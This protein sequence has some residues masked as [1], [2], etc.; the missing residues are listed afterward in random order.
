MIRLI[1]GVAKLFVWIIS[2]V[3]LKGFFSPLNFSCSHSAYWREFFS[4]CSATSI[5]SGMVSVVFLSL[6][7]NYPLNK[8][9]AYL[10]LYLLLLG[11][12]ANIRADFE[13]QTL[14][15]HLAVYFWEFLGVIIGLI[16]AK[17]W[18]K[19]RDY[20]V[21]F[22]PFLLMGIYLREEISQ[23]ITKYFLLLAVLVFVAFLINRIRGKFLITAVG[24]NRNLEKN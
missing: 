12:L 8:I 3:I 7:I 24:W 16:F 1:D 22:P 2:L 23:Q 18:F 15:K 10:I 5:A 19:W 17:D 13:I 11:I 4:L 20:S 9:A 14:V 6:S 21:V